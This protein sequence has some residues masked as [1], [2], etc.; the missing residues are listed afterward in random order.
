LRK[1]KRG[2]MRNKCPNI[3]VLQGRIY[4]RAKM[5]VY[6]GLVNYVVYASTKC[7][8]YENGSSCMIAMKITLTRNHKHGGSGEMACLGLSA[9]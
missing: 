9:I 1:F 5:H 7:A 6:A 2:D 4:T 3:R 8:F